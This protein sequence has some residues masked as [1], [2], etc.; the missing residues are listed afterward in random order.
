MKEEY[1]RTQRLGVLVQRELADIFQREVRDA[2]L[3][4]L[5]IS[6]VKISPDLQRAK[7]YL[8]VLGNTLTIAQVI[9]S[10]NHRAGL[11]RHYLAQRLTTRTT[12]QLHFVYDESAEYASR[13][14]ALLI[15]A[16]VT[17]QEKNKD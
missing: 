4:L 2:N 1:S 11:L 12:P 3:G 17:P 8:T 16:A 13:I 10:L 9:E 7:V 14:S 15:D 5:T 6:E